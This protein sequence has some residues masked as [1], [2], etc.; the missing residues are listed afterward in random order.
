MALTL[1]Y[2]GPLPSSQSKGAGGINRN[3]IKQAIRRQLHPQIREYVKSNPDKAR[4]FEWL[5]GDIAGTQGFDNQ[6]VDWSALQESFR[7]GKFTFLPLIFDAAH[8][9]CH[10][11]IQFLRHEKIGSLIVNV[12]KNGGDLDN[13]LKTF[14]DALQIP[15]PEQIPNGDEPCSDEEP[16]YCLLQDDSLVTNFLV[17]SKTLF[18]PTP[19][20]QERDV[21]LIVD[22][23]V[24]FSRRTW[25]NEALIL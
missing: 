5:R 3:V 13:R 7:R 6:E 10:L 19:E 16:F 14:F 25:L 1:M 9:I 23:T 2:S 11:N 18:T 22:V 15:K 12:G 20:G 21:V 17:E 8:A 24:T 4:L